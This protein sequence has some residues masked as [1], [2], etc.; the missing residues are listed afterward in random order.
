MTRHPG[1]AAQVRIAVND[2]MD[3]HPATDPEDETEPTLTMQVAPR[4]TNTAT[5]EYDR[6]F[7]PKEMWE[8]LGY[9]GG[10]I[11]GMATRVSN[12][13]SYHWGSPDP[14]KYT[15][16]K[17]HLED[18]E[19][20]TAFRLLPFQVTAVYV[21]MRMIILG[22]CGFNFDPVGMGKTIVTIAVYAVCAHF[23]QYY[24]QHGH[25]PGDFGTHTVFPGLCP[26]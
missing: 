13:P 6:D 20:S 18:A 15:E 23:R 19:K 1:E 22:Q 11:P 8:K 16:Y 9:P 14:K 3:S 17:S 10:Y 24:R 7:S 25:F 21:M 2:Y 4:L 26:P 12:D 5:T